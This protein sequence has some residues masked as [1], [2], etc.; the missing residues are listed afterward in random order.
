MAAIHD[1][2]NDRILKQCVEQFITSRDSVTSQ[3]CGATGTEKLADVR[4]EMLNKRTVSKEKACQWLESLCSLLGSV[5]ASMLESSSQLSDEVSK[6]KNE[7][8]ANSE[9]IIGLQS[10]LIEKHEEDMA[11][12][13]ELQD[14]LIVKNDEDLG[15][16]KTVVQTEMK[17]YSS[18]L[19]NTCNN[20]F[21]PKKI[22]A[23]VRKVTEEGDRSRNLI[24]YGLEENDLA[25]LDRG[26][27][28][29]LEHL[30]EKPEILEVCRIGEKSGDRDRPIKFTLRS[31]DTV[32]RILQK[33]KLLRDVSGYEEIYLSPDRSP[34]ERE[35]LTKNSLNR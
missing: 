7:K 28:A 16:M 31:S 23:A 17:T 6:L 21:A 32:K 3:I 15:A 13:T 24:M 35:L 2:L 14:K 1:T 34:K 19:K 22:H 5:S 4:F 27:V 10:K 11:K 29:V 12:I 9:T 25:D 33:T 8:I 18:L 30:N 26:V 20:A